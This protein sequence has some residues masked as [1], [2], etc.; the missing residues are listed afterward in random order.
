M[1]ND[2]IWAVVITGKWGVRSSPRRKRNKQE[3]E[4]GKEEREG[5]GEGRS[6]RAERVRREGRGWREGGEGEERGE[7]V[8]R[9]GRGW[10]VS[11]QY[12]FHFIFICL[13]FLFLL[14][15]WVT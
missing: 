9:E 4:K 13:S 8:G 11:R 12:D 5:G 7:R 15:Y 2:A 14:P 10:G 6:G 3:Q 1:T